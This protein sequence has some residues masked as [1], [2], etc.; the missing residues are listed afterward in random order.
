MS[1]PVYN[2]EGYSNEEE[3]FSG[4]AA[5]ALA[6]VASNHPEVAFGPD[7]LK[8]IRKEMERNRRA[9]DPA[10]ERL[11]AALAEIAKGEGAYSR[12]PLIH[13]GNTIDNMKGIAKAALAALEGRP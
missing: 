6:Q 12:D 10:V 9:P 11:I 1:E 3:A 4:P 7:D 2:E 13:A 8:A 5:E